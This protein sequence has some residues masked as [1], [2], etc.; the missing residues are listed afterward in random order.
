MNGTVTITTGVAIAGLP[1]AAGLVV[2]AMAT[3]FV[4]AVIGVAM[5]RRLAITAGFVDRPGGRK[6]HDRPIAL[7]GGVGIFWA[8]VLP[9]SVGLLGAWLVQAWGLWPW[10]ESML[11]R[12]TGADAPALIGGLVQDMPM[13]LAILAGATVMHIPGLIDDRKAL[14]PAP[15]FLVQIGVA[16][17]LAIGFDL[18]IGT[19]LGP[20]A[21][22]AITILWL[23]AVMNS[24]N[25]LDNMDG[26]SAGVAVI[27][28]S[29][30]V[31]TG[32]RGGQVFVPVV[33]AVVAGA[34]GG[35]LVFNFPPASV[36]MGDAGSLL[37]GYMLG[38]LTVLTTYYDPRLNLQPCGVFLPLVVLAVPMYDTASVM[39]HRRRAGASF[40]V[41]DHR[42]FSHR[43]RR[44]GLSTR[45][46]VLTIHLATLA[47]ALPAMLLPRVSG[48]MAAI[49]LVQTV[50]ILLIIAILEHVNPDEST[51]L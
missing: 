15:K 35:F 40:F 22:S 1:S 45:A 23:V 41:G 25:F 4:L 14:G 36:F 32:L 21:A 24:M 26:R 6:A 27:A 7:G 51:H 18:R 42:H 38:V 17:V 46:T 49:I 12:F 30:L 39:W 11:A 47:T 48:A 37:L 33:A 10:L 50:C 5:V 8:M 19:F 3:G 13:A 9:L 43:L 28:A 29:V 34:A 31:A 20:V 2:V 44:R 16:A